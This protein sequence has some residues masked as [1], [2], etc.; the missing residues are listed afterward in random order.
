MIKLQD[1]KIV[2]INQDSYQNIR[3]ETPR[4]SIKI[5]QTIKKLTFSPYIK[6]FFKCRPNLN[7]K[8]SFFSQHSEPTIL[9]TL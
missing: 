1:K 4:K 5:Y 8:N 2:K 6:Q 7:G 3:L 9:I